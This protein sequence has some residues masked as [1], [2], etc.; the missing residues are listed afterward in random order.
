MITIYEAKDGKIFEANSKAHLIQLMYED[1]DSGKSAGVPFEK[2][3]S[4]TATRSS[5]QTGKSID[6]STPE[7]LADSLIEVGLV[8]VKN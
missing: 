8:A 6:G 5:F 4:E 7:T 2:W 3:L 1:S